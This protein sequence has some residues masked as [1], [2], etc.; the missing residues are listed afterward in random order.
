MAAFSLFDLPLTYHRLGQTG[1]QLHGSAVTC[2]EGALLILGKAGDGKSSYAA[3]HIASGAL[4]VADDQVVCSVQSGAVVLAAPRNI[5]GVLALRAHGLMRT[6]AVE[7]A[8]LAGVVLL[9]PEWRNHAS[10]IEFFGRYFPCAYHGLSEA[11]L[12]QAEAVYAQA[13][14]ANQ[15]LAEDWMPKVA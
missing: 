15:L 7:H 12:R 1:M 4:L 5:H 3:S 13:R 14:Q 11:T 2:E 10:R 6:P 9:S 8:P